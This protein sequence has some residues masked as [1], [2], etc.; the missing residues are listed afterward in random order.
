MFLRKFTVV[1]DNFRLGKYNVIAWVGDVPESQSVADNST[2]PI[3][4]SKE[5][6]EKRA[7]ELAQVEQYEFEQYLNDLQCDFV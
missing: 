5:Q 2:N 3:F 1:E 4:D 6:A 7:A